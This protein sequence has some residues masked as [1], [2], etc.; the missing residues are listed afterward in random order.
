VAVISLEDLPSKSN[1][2]K[3]YIMPYYLGYS[4]PF[5]GTFNIPAGVGPDFV[6]ELIVN[7]FKEEGVDVS[8]KGLNITIKSREVNRFPQ[9]LD[10]V[11]LAALEKP[12]SSCPF[13]TSGEDAW[14]NLKNLKLLK[15]QPKI[16]SEGVVIIGKWDI[17]K[18]R[19][20]FP[21]RYKKK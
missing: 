8:Q 11:G 2:T 4:G 13:P 18:G 12:D 19:F 15:G 21:D 6:A 1:N 14:A 5:I 17:E 10:R 16:G 9:K 3:G 20:D 7:Q